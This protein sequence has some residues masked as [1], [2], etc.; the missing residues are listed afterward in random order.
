MTWLS[1]CCAINT[2]RLSLAPALILGAITLGSPA[3]AAGVNSHNYT[4]PELQ[5]L[6]LSNRFIF[7]NNP[8]FEDFVVSDVSYCSGS[9]I[10][11]RRS[12]PTKDEPECAVNYCLPPRSTSGG[13]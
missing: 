5:R 2:S 13:N 1:G 6:I 9:G 4:C 11:Q 12:V 8:N 7:I 10:L 3:F